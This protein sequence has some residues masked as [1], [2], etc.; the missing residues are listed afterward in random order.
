MQLLRVYIQTERYGNFVYAFP[1]LTTSKNYTVRLHFAE[2]WF[3]APNMR[4]FNV[5]LNGQRVLGN[6]DVYAAAGAKSK[7]VVKDF[8][9]TPNAQGQIIIAF[10]SVVDNAMVNGIE[11]IETTATTSTTTLTQ[12]PVDVYPNPAVDVV[13]INLNVTTQEAVTVEV[14]NSNTVV[15]KKMSMTAMPNVPLT[16]QLGDVNSGTY[17][18]RIT[19]LIRLT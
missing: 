9:T 18:L 14:I 15:V 11:I 16:I 17:Y 13:N 5:D 7:A 12:K 6:F 4:K 8:N 2:N 19:E 1:G 3:N 10:A